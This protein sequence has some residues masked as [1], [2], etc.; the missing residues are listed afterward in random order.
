MDK[1]PKSVYLLCATVQSPPQLH[2]HQTR[3]QPP[4]TMVKPSPLRLMSKQSLPRHHHPPWHHLLLPA[5]RQS[6][7]TV[8]L[9]RVPRVVLLV[10]AL[11]P[12]PTLPAR[13]P[14]PSECLWAGCPTPG[15]R[16]MLDLVHARNASPPQ[17]SFA[18][19]LAL[20]AA[21]AA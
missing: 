6:L 9:P 16:R 4:A 8:P 5:W 21:W 1:L 7:L 15:P 12:A 13:P 10:P 19:A 18:T 3:H 20:T 2:A 14:P 17:P 11:S